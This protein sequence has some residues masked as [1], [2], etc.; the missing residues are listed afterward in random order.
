MTCGGDESD[1]VYRIVQNGAAQCSS[2][3]PRTWC[4][5]GSLVQ[6]TGGAMAQ[7]LSTA[8]CSRTN[9]PRHAGCVGGAPIVLSWP[10]QCQTPNQRRHLVVRPW[11]QATAPTRCCAV[12]RQCQRRQ[13][14]A[15]LLLA[16]LPQHPRCL[17]PLHCCYHPRQFP[18]PHRYR[19]RS[20]VRGLSHLAHRAMPNHV[21]Q[22]CRC[23]WR[24]AAAAPRA[25][26]GRVRRPLPACRPG[27]KRCASC[28]GWAR[29]PAAATTTNASATNPDG[30]AQH[31]V[32]QRTA[33]RQQCV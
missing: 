6:L 21:A 19:C 2:E 16:L 31:S 29:P 32:S 15:Q 33:A 12:L 8:L 3:C 22:R 23:R 7:R 14:C 26:P 11:Q 1:N 28:P 20:F 10:G 25:R 18:Q 5:Q 27:P 30:A 9:L 13:Q 17:P 24:G 4:Q